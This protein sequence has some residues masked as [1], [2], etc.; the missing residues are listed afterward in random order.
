MMQA[1]AWPSLGELQLLNE[2]NPVKQRNRAERSDTR[3]TEKTGQVSSL[4]HA[5][6]ELLSMFCI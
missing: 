4:V 5:K 6:A 3:A 1:A 2:G